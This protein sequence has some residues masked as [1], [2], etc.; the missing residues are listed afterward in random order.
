MARRRFCEGPPL[1]SG[2]L[3]EKRESGVIGAHA[4]FLIVGIGASAGGIQALSDF[5]AHVA[6][7]SGMAYVVILHMSPDHE[8]KLAE[9]LQ[10][11]VPIPVTQVRERVKVEPNHVYVVSPNHSLQMKDGYL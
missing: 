1:M 11:N 8:S 9:V 7:D 4:E 3:V 5:F 2:A 6:P 10:S